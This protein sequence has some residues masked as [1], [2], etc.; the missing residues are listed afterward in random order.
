MSERELVPTRRLLK[1]ERAV[2][3]RV[4]SQFSHLK[5]TDEDMLTR[6]SEASVTYTEAVRQTKKHPTVKTPV[7]NRSTGNVT[8]YKE[9]RNT[10]Y[11]TVSESQSQL[12]SLARRLLI[13]AASENKRL[14]LQSKLSRA[15]SGLDS[16]ARSER[17]IL[18]SLTE[19]QITFKMA[20]RECSRESAIDLLTNP[21]VAG[22]EHLFHPDYNVV[23]FGGI[24]WD[25]RDPEAPPE[26]RDSGL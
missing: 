5:Q 16:L 17:E 21:Y 4:A 26:A 15:A 23:M 10:A 18:A 12:N 11:R 8:G 19:E 24:E 25:I 3:D 13:D 14:L 6:Y 2:F 22:N 9:V 1:K 20:E 7:I